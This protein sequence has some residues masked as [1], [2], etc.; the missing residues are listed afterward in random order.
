MVIYTQYTVFVFVLSIIHESVSR[1]AQA[2]L[3]CCEARLLACTVVTLFY[4]Q[5]LLAKAFQNYANIVT[6]NVTIYP[7]LCSNHNIFHHC[8]QNTL[9]TQHTLYF[10]YWGHCP[11]RLH[12]V[13]QVK[14]YHFLTLRIRFPDGL[15][16]R[17]LAVGSFYMHAFIYCPQICCCFLL[18][19]QESDSS[20]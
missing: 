1:S 15:K 8:Q 20:S 16:A 2:R 13:Q 11:S 12:D 9:F 4:R 17:H 6:I 5:L 18:L 3:T 7:L 10:I 14:W 19:P